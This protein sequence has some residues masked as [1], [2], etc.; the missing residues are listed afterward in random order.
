MPFF[1]LLLGAILII[2]ALNN[3]QGALATELESDVP[4][5]LKWGLAIGAIGGL[6][7]VPG[8][9]QISRWLLALVLVVIVLKNYQQMIAGFQALGGT[10]AS[11]A[12][13]AQTSNPTPAAAYIANP[14]QPATTA[15][16]ITGSSADAVNINAAAQTATVA[17]PFGPFDPGHFLAAFE[18]GFGGF[19]GVV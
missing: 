6:G 18:A 10:Q 8:L 11:Q 2:A 13:A 16:Q 14:N 4:P 19:G 1:L 7:W 9:Q 15:A 5:F 17:S 3:S 12:S